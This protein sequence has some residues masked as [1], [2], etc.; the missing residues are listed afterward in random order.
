M[1][2]RQVSRTSADPASRRRTDEARSVGAAGGV[3]STITVL[4]SCDSR[5]TLSRAPSRSV[6]V[7][8]ADSGSHV[9]SVPASMEA[10]PRSS[11]DQRYA[12]AREPGATSSCQ[13]AMFASLA[14][15]STGPA[16]VTYPP[17]STLVKATT[18]GVPSS[19]TVARASVDWPAESAATRLSV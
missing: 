12:S 11:S 3:V 10:S 2:A 5:P 14:L 6:Y 17:S 1:L 8:S 18:G 7:P 9:A 15:P 16:A 13:D 4:V 19:R